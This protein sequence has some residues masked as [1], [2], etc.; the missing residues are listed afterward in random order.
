MLIIEITMSRCFYAARVLLPGLFTAQIL[1][2]VQV[3]LSNMRLYR[4]LMAIMEAGYLPIPN[5]EIM[6]NLQGFGPAFFGGLFFTLSV[7]AGLSLLSLGAVWLWDCLLSR[8]KYV[9]ILLLLLWVACLVEVNRQGLNPMVTSYFLFIPSVVFM[10]TLKWMPTQS[11]KGA[12]RNRIVHLSPVFLLALLWFTQMDSHLFLDLRDNLLLSNRFG[13][14]IN[15]FYY[16]YTLYPAEV[17]KS[18]DQKILKTCRIENIQNNFMVRSIEKQ[19]IN[20]D[21][22]YAGSDSPVDLKIVQEGNN[23][24]FNNRGRTILKET[25]RDFFSNP[26]KLL[27]EFS[28]RSDRHRF[29]RQF[30]FFSLLIGFPL[31]L[32]IIFFALVSMLLC[33]FLDIR[34]S[35]VMASTLCFVIG[36]ILLV[37][38]HQ[39]RVKSN[40]VNNVAEALESER[41]QKRVAALKS[42][43]Q[44]GLEIG[45]FRAYCNMLESPHIPERYW[46]AKSLGASR[47]SETYKDLLG[48]LDDLHP[49]VVSM[50]FYALGKRGDK[51]A[52]SEILKRIEISRNWYNQWYAYNALRKLGWKQTRLK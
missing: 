49:N 9:S 2:T 40:E 45:N 6:Q 17:F 20:Y 33:L 50:A 41:W 34:T 10:A 5:Q 21:Y 14:K 18:L 12:W 29:F 15:D 26:G 25:P 19:L 11:G 39:G 1:A 52:V 16:K 23:L 47:R 43:E 30:T 27:K 31:T 4:T 48:F 24:A 3:Y 22:L 32:Y 35:S 13:T 28:S 38:F 37:I 8:N 7:G 42:I 46:L 44:Q 36:I 51:R